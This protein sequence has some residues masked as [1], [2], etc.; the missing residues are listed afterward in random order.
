MSGIVGIINLDGAPVDRPL[1]QQMTDFIAFRGPDAQAIWSNGPVGFGHT[2]LRTWE[3]S[4]RESQPCSLEGDIWITADARVDGQSE[5]IRKLAARG[6]T[7]LEAATDAEL[8][9]HAYHVWGDDCVQHLL[10]DF[11]FALWDGRR[12]RLFCARDHFGVKLFY[13]AQVANTLVFGN[14]LECLRLHPA[15][16]DTLNELAIADFLL[17]GG[18]EDHDTTTFAD[19]QRLRPAYRLTWSE[20]D[21][22]PRRSRYWTLSI[23]EEIRYKRPGDYVERF[24]EL[25]RAVVADRLDTSHVGVLMSGGL[26]STSIAATA[27]AVL[28]ERDEPFD[29]R[30]FVTYCEWLFPDQERH[31][32]ALAAEALR[33]PIHYQRVE[34]HALYER[35]DAPEMRMPEP[36]DLALR[37]LFVDRNRCMAAHTRVVLTGWDGD[38]L[39]SER[40]HRYFAALLKHRRFGRWGA[41]LVRYV[42]SL[43]ELPRLGVRTELRRWLGKL[44]AADSLFPTW[45]QRDFVERLQ[46]RARWETINATPVKSYPTRPYGFLALTSRGWND[47][48]EEYDAGVTRL[49]L[50]F[51]HPLLDLR[52]VNYLLSIPPV[53]W[54]MKKYMLRLVMRGILP[55]PVRLRPKNTL[56]GDPIFELLRRDKTGWIDS[57]EPTGELKRFVAKEKLPRMAGANVLEGLRI[58]RS[59]LNLN[60]WFRH[61][62]RETCRGADDV[63]PILA[64]QTQRREVSPGALSPP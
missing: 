29:L 44:P 2:M 18:N 38:A 33:I 45:L 47:L 6:R 41:D 10:G 51:R 11:A 50:E 42:W 13:Y 39:F 35:W 28:S 5:L 46:L 23:G 26:D 7:R 57:F 58:K 54:C 60:C 16:S 27:R 30:A 49:P 48:F 32:A 55:E 59:P 43:G 34:D 21:G 37:A 31:F 20:L 3:G 4:I 61:A 64:D 53:P 62:M 63:D 12:Q 8:I 9:L 22:E 56:G 24:R 25:L 15:V 14:T 17:F 36:E 40:P 1:L 52:L 19:I